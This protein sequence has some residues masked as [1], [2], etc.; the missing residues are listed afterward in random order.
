MQTVDTKATLAEVRE[1]VEEAREERISRRLEHIY[2]QV[3]ANDCQQCAKCCFNGAQVHPIEFLN[4]YDHIL[5]M[6]ELDQARLAKKLI[7]YELLHMATLDVECPFL[8]EKH[9]RVYESRPLQ[10]RVF[11]LYPKQDH[12]KR[13]AQGREANEQLAMYYARNHRVLLP[14]EVMTHD[15]EQC[16]NNVREDGTVVVVGERERQHLHS[17]VYSLGEQ[18]LPEEWLSFDEAGFASQF[19]ELFFAAEALE[20]MKVTVIKEHQSGGKRKR[21]DKILSTSGLKF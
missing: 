6:P 20:E 4:V 5:Q 18:F 7:E 8:D 3:P 14:E 13:K 9:C 17:Q 10:C 16:E 11:G 12:E 2:R 15:I 19:A 1:L 21:L